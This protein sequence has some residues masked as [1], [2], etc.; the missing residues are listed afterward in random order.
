MHN[1]P[2]PLPTH[3]SPGP[4]DI[5]ALPRWDVFCQVVDNFGDI[6]VCW[7]LARQLAGE[8]CIHVRLWVDDLAS[9][10]RL[11]PGLDSQAAVQH[12]EG[13]AI[14]RWEP[15][16][17][18]EQAADVVIAAFAC[19]LP[20]VYKRAM[21][22]RKQR[23][24]WINLE[25]LSAEDWVAGCHG[26]PSPQP[27]LPLVQHFFFPGFD[28]ASGG[29]LREADYAA[30]QA[31]FDPDAWWQTRVGMPRPLDALTVSLFAY[32]N[33]G[34]APLLDVWARGARPVVCLVP[35]GRVLADL[36]AWSGQPGLKAGDGLQR[37]ALR[38]QVLPF[39][40][41]QAYD[42]L[43]WACDL[44]FV[45]GEDSFVRAQWAAKP[46]VW[47]IY[48]QEEEAH[49]VK[50]E[51]FLARQG[52]GLDS[53]ARNAQEAFWRAWNGS[54][55]GMGVA[56]A[57]PALEAALPRLAA[58]GQAWAREMEA[59]GDLASGLLKFCKLAVQ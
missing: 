33:P 49:M 24:V 42:E 30:R 28:A 40:P 44:N 13:V 11:I 25:Y 43:L 7:R 48:R 5:R 53:A 50:L 26:L 32:E 9:A 35:E 10:A 6:G 38:L 29:L 45:R 22:A 46:L 8:F 31:A 17:S 59:L 56:E 54:E 2:L 39:V 36:A 41:Q 47:H 27:G 34:L 12:Q 15:D 58:H 55:G 16:F 21:A 23:P 37:G 51:A 3:L 4:G 1:S 20:D 18:D 14:H 19:P 57:W 52:A